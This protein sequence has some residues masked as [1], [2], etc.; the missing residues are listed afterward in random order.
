M[1]IIRFL[2]KIVVFPAMLIVTVIQWLGAFII[3]FSSI[4]FNIFAGL[5]F[6]VAV[7]SFLMGLSA[8]AEAA[9]MILAG[10]IIFMIPIIG[11]WFIRIIAALNMRIRKK[12]SS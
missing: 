4:V 9:K 11:E 7:L 5:F 3:G 2:M 10:F 8:G 6:L 1:R 12:I